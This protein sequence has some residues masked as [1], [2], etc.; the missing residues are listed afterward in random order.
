MV[1][2]HVAFAYLSFPELSPDLHSVKMPSRI[3][4][5]VVMS[6]PDFLYNI[7][8]V[9]QL[10]K[11]NLSF[12]NRPPLFEKLY[13]WVATHYTYL[14]NKHV[15]SS[16]L[17]A[18]ASLSLV[19]TQ[20]LL[21]SA[22]PLMAIQDYKHVSICSRSKYIGGVYLYLIRHNWKKWKSFFVDR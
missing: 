19:D 11:D 21:L 1:S 3:G 16:P 9:L 12:A 5:A 10:F 18:Q 7:T 4:A 13:Q 20:V 14:H 8:N 17:K 22:H 2:S 15:F 6:Y